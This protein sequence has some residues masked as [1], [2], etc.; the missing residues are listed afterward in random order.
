MEVNPTI[1]REYDIRGI[2]G[3]EF[4]P[5]MIQEYERWYGSFPGITITLEVAK[6]IGSA[7]G[8]MIRREGGREVVVGYELRPFAKELTDAFIEGVLETGCNVTDLGI[9]LTPIVYFI[10]AHNNFDGGV[11]VTGSHNI[12]FYNGFKLMKKGVA[13]IFGEALQEMRQMIAQ[14]EFILGTPGQRKTLEGYPIYKKYF[15]EHVR[16]DRHFKIVI[17]SGNG[18]AG[19]FAPD[20]FRSLGC[21]VIELYSEP[22]ATFPNHTPD[23]HMSQFMKDLSERVRTEKADLGI[24][25]DADA[26]RVGFVLETGDL[27]EPDLVTLAFAKDVLSRHPGK[28]ILFTAKGSQLPEE[29]VPKYGGVYL[30]HR[31]GHAPIKDTM[32]LDDKIIFAGEDTA[33]YFFVEDYYKIDDGL[34]AAGKLLEIIARSQGSFST[35]FKGIPERIRTPEI[36]IPCRDE[37]KFIIIKKIQ[38]NL[39][40]RYPSIT[41]DGV[42]IKVS[43]TGWGLIRASNTTPYLSVRAEGIS[44]EEVL[45]IKN[46]LADELEKYPAILDKLNRKEIATLTGKL[47]WV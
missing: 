20:L 47:G 30:M 7:Y 33:H 28:K 21:E 13:P 6:A 26:D 31:N 44:R 35:L 46:I 1:F 42:R 22:D 37:D 32:R 5:K 11:N 41:I 4:P 9:S 25:F 40:S 14:R 23:P 10:T 12:Y 17:D 8:T 24:G 3:T 36:K 19:M 16:L 45:K 18:S 39:S 43:K 15:L 29:L 2:A 34:W 27:I 38:E